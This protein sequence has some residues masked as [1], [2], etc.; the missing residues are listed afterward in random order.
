MYY[1]SVPD[2]FYS[3]DL[4]QYVFVCVRVCVCVTAYYRRL[5]GGALV[6]VLYTSYPFAAYVDHIILLHYVRRSYSILYTICMII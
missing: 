5:V 2:T 3:Q 1:H 6:C 4:T